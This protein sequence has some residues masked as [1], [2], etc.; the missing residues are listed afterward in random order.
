MA[1]NLEHDVVGDAAAD[2]AGEGLERLE[3]VEGPQR[4][5]PVGAE[6][7]AAGIEEGHELK[8]GVAV[9]EVEMQVCEVGAL[10]RN[11]P[12]ET[13][14]SSICSRFENAVGAFSWVPVGDVRDF[15]GL[16]RGFGGWCQS[17][18]E[19]SEAR[20]AIEGERG[21]RI[22]DVGAFGVHLA[23]H[24][25]E[26]DGAGKRILVSHES[27]AVWVRSGVLTE[28]IAT[29]E[30]VTAHF[31]LSLVDVEWQGESQKMRF[32][33]MSQPMDRVG[34][35]GDEVLVDS[36]TELAREIKEAKRPRLGGSDITRAVHFFGQAN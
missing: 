20:Y 5:H 21:F 19:M 28:C 29:A 4:H 32:M 36:Q 11:L 22:E 13:F 14:P 8:L 12:A 1:H 25:E 3:A 35:C 2:M 27:G 23:A 33:I 24:P 10:V 26:R 6:E 16:Q 18:N 9:V 15:D 17:I 34:V 7:M 30:G 31:G